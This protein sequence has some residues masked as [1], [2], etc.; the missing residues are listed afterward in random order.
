MS[1][2]NHSVP[3]PLTVS[4]LRSKFKP[5][6]I[7]S[8]IGAMFMVVALAAGCVTNSGDK[9]TAGTLLGAGLGG[10]AGAQIGDGR[11]QLAAVAAG[12]LIGAMMGSEAGASLDRADQ[13]YMERAQTQAQAAPIGEPIVWNNPDSGPTGTVVATREGV[14]QTSGKLC[15]EYR[16]T[17]YVGGEQ[18]DAYGTACR[19]EDGSWTIVH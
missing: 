10:L 9:Q 5:R 8:R 16:H 4:G 12:A 1:T 18:Q 13:A 19:E 11:G 3:A 2:L 15:R 17:V 14:T 7:A 6:S